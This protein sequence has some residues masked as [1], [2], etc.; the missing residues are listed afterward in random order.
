MPGRKQSFFLSFLTFA[1]IFVYNL[2]SLCPTTLPLLPSFPNYPLPFLASSFKKKSDLLPFILLF[3]Y[4]HL[5]SLPFLLC[6]C[7][8]S[9]CSNASNFFFPAVCSGIPASTPISALTPAQIQ[10]L[11]TG[12]DKML[13]RNGKTFPGWGRWLAEE[14]GDCGKEDL[15]RIQPDAK[16]AI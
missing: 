6:A 8:S 13:V 1:L 16:I 3:P 4:S 14:S 15:L 2:S 12:V 7:T 11:A 10:A 9:S 5:V